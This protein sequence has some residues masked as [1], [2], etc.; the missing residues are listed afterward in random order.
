MRRLLHAGYALCLVLMAHA[1]VAGIESRGA[2]LPNGLA[3]TP[4]MGWDSWNRFGCNINQRLIERTAS[5]IVS[6]GMRDA[7]YRYVILDDCWEGPRDA[8]G[9]IRPDPTRFPSGMK[10][11]GDYL[12]ARGLKFGI[13]STA[14]LRTCAGRPGSE[15]Y[16]FADARQYATWGVDYLKYDWCNTGTR[17][18]QAAYTLMED[19]L[20]ATGRKIVFAICD[21]SSKPWLWAN[22]V[23]NLWRT[24]NDIYDAWE[25]RDAYRLGV[26][27]ILDRQ[28]RLWPFA[29]PGHWN[30]PDM[31]EVGN[32]GMS[33]SEY[34]AHFS[35]WAMLAAPLIAGNDVSHMNAATRA[36]LLNREMIAIDQDPLGRE[37]RRVLKRGDQEVW[38]RPLV[39]GGRAV[40]FL[41]RGALPA[42][43]SVPSTL[44][45]YPAHLRLAVR[46]LWLHESVAPQLG[47]L[48]AFVQPRAAVVYRVEP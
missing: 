47:R 24:S 27:N 43:I 30:D 46:D 36:I 32:G 11:L 39:D 15:G 35:L 45:G 23:G 1:A 48:S 29:G 5:A 13:Y 4:P 34:R 41:N 44:I 26:L 18:P 2:R 20:L 31:L 10:A 37:A 17:N 40:L 7:G 42:K 21:S 14:G 6:S 38:S 16:E 9:H 28:V 12:H 33:D 22:K 25:G 8:D 3:L 19:A